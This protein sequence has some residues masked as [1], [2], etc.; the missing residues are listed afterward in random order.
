MPLLFLILSLNIFFHFD[1]KGWS[2]KFD[3]NIF[4]EPE[5]QRVLA[6]DKVPKKMFFSQSRL[7]MA[8]QECILMLR[9]GAQK[10]IETFLKSPKIRES[11]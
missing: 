10:S 3:M 5:N 7:D 1:V 4:E 6:G 2:P 11:S 8:M 9:V